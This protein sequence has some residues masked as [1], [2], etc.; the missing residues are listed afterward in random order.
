MTDAENDDLIAD[1]AIADDVG[2]GRHDFAHCGS[3]NHAAAMREIGEA[4]AC[5][6]NFRCDLACR[7]W[8][9]LFDIVPDGLKIRH[10]RVS[11][12]D[13]C[14]MAFGV[15]RGNSCGVPHDFSHSTTLS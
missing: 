3:M 2:I 12:Y 11:P 7:V 13:C 9:K 5:A 8:V 15:G 10:R 1:N 14:Q 6:D 4:V